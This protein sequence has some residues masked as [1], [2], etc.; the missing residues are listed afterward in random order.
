[1]A[2][3]LAFLEWN[4]LNSLGLELFYPGSKRRLDQ[5]VDRTQKNIYAVFQLSL[6]QSWQ[7]LTQDTTGTRLPVCP[8]MSVVTVMVIVGHLD[9]VGDG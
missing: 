8:K 6:F 1:M 5:S 3:P 2:C 7:S 9:I 4:V